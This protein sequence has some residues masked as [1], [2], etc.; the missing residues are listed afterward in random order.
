MPQLILE[1]DLLSAIMKAIDPGLVKAYW[2]C[3]GAIHSNNDEL[4]RQDP[5][6][7]R[8]TKR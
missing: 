5:A 2:V 4:D 8:C 3:A 7:G 1:T 6:F